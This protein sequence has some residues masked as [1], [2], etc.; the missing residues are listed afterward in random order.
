MYRNRYR[1]I[2]WFFGRVILSFIWWDIILSKIG[3]R[4]VSRR[5]RNTRMRKIAA[6]FRKVAVQMGGVMIKVGQ[7]L[8]SRLDVLPRIITDELTGLQD[9][10]GPEKVEDIRRVMEKEFGET[11]EARY[12]WFEA[13]PTASASIGQVHRARVTV[14]DDGGTRQP[15]EVVVK[16]QRPDIEKIVEV[17]LAALRIVAGWLM[18]YP[19]I[20]KRANVP[21]LLEEFS[22]SLME[23]L[24]YLNEGKNAEVF[25]KNFSSDAQ[26]QSPGVV[27]SHTTRRVLTLEFIDA[28]KISDYAALDAAGISRKEVAEKL[29]AT[30]LK[31]IFD[32]R[33]F[34]A[35]PHPGNLFVRPVSGP[36]AD[37]AGQ[38]WR[39]VFVDF[40]M[41]GTISERL[42]GEFREILIAVGTKDSRRIVRSYQS[43]GV[44][45]PG[46]DVELLIRATD[47]VFER[48]WG[49]TAPEMMQMHQEEAVA[50]VQD[51]GE[52][53]FDMPFQ[54][55]E[56]LILFARG[57]GILSG[58]CT[59][60]YHEFNV[61]TSIAPYA[62]KLVA[63]EDQGGWRYWLGEIGSMVTVLA[64][65]PRKTDALL[66]KL[67]QGKLEVQ[68]PE[69]ERRVNRL[70]RS[71]RA[72]GTAVVFVGFLISS[73]QLYLANE[74]VIASVLAGGA[75]IALGILLFRKQV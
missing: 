36:E 24:D 39:L 8:S 32:D 72:L 17:D 7:F 19:P 57:M 54:V 30:Y 44:L 52:L 21:V 70:E 1:Q 31:Q 59:G 49:K 25:A 35:D 74:M 46:A 42:L 27:W 61:W 51:F 11:V 18:R 16:V 50:F 45:L 53:I 58:I 23:E 40:G 12:T 33:F 65:L 48:F 67:E 47:R 26:V 68:M 34:H 63:A 20:R 2:L 10:V 60:L 3:L 38:S 29:F 75:V 62:K 37:A 41:T 14:L 71:S 15:Q 5:T 13:T 28:I 6:D 66:T 43:L 69:L 64:G 55:P 9:E 56:N 4:W 22:R 73:V